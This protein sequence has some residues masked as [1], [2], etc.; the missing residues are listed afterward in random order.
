MP[1]PSHRVLTPGIELDDWLVLLSFS[2]LLFLPGEREAMKVPGLLSLHLPSFGPAHIRESV[3]FLVEPGLPATDYLCRR[4]I[5][6]TDR[7]QWGSM[8]D[9]EWPVV[10]VCVSRLFPTDATSPCRPWVVPKHGCSLLVP[11]VEFFSYVSYMSRDR[12]LAGHLHTISQGDLKFAMFQ[13][14]LITSYLSRY[15]PVFLSWWMKYSAI[16]LPKPQC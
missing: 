5:K 11:C 3:L 7:L 14:K 13:I 8:A 10:C 15:A 2:A 12:W 9:L 4:I 16:Q 1:L 6:A